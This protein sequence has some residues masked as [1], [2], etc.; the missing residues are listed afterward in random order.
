MNIRGFLAIATVALT[1]TSLNGAATGRP[2]S[3]PAASFAVISG[4]V[5]IVGDNSGAP[6]RRATVTL[7]SD[8]GTLTRTFATDANGAF[9]FDGLAAGNYRVSVE[10][11]GFLCR[12]IAP[13]PRTTP[14]MDSRNAFPELSVTTG[15]QHVV[16]FTAERAAALEGRLIEDTGRPLADLAITADRLTG[17]RGQPAGVES[18]SAKTDDLGRFRIH[19]LEAGRYRVSFKPPS[20][21]SGERLYYPGTEKVEDAGIIDIASGQ[22]IGNLTFA[23][24]T[25]SLPAMAAEAMANQELDASSAPTRGG[26]WGQISGRVT[27]ADFGQPI[28]NVAVKLSMGGVLVRTTWTDGAGEYSFRRVMAGNYQIAVSADGY[29]NTPPGGT[30]FTVADG[31]RAKKELVMIALVAIEGRVVD[32]FGE[33]APGVVLRVFSQAPAV[34]RLETRPTPITPGTT[35]DRGW[36]RISGLVAGD[37]QLVA[38]PEPFARSGPAAFPI[39]AAPLQLTAGNDVHGVSLVVPSVSTTAITGTVTDTAGR[40]V[41]KA[42][43]TLSPAID[44]PVQAS[45]RA[46][47][48]VDANG[49]FVFSNV[50]VGTY[51]VEGKNGPFETGSV[52]ITA[53]VD[54]FAVT[55]KA[56]PTARGRVVFEG[57]V[58]RQV[59]PQMSEIVR[60][61]M[62]RFVPVGGRI[63]EAIMLGRPGVVASDWTF[64][65]S[66][67]SSPGLIR[68]NEEILGFSLA[69]VVVNGRDVTDVPYD[70]QSG[71]VEGI[72]VVLTNRVGG[73]TGMVDDFNGDPISVVVFGADGDSWPYLSR[74]LRTFSTTLKGA[75]TERG[76]LPGRYF[77]IAVSSTT[78]RNTPEA[79][80]AL[81][82]RATQVVVTE[83]A[84]TPVRLSIVK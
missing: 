75:F 68:T 78:A 22:T 61:S 76:L 70:P 46:P 12:A 47:G 7:R 40:R 38:L 19:T 37:Y 82:S 42:L 9:R 48:N 6:L 44:G 8:T 30:R 28:P 80:A 24:A 84:D 5:E 63:E 15:S 62:L 77:V 36:F 55:L 35:D 29:V 57:G 1:L 73:I 14:G 50:P 60:H 34:N 71:D 16:N 81:R 18:Y 53:P 54:P 39:T 31:E 51:V 64:Q 58:P 20:P 72:E 41:P 74:T 83:G 33:P 11:A 2:Q 43:V 4:R 45:L 17:E 26:T 23:V 69:R 27:R 66:G 10:K 79:L 25:A 13:T 59:S 56:L 49:N 32:E 65:I 52:T 21:A 67:L 3:P